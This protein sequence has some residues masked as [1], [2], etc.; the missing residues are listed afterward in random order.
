M[1]ISPRLRRLLIA[2]AGY[3]LALAAGIAVLGVGEV[4]NIL[5]SPQAVLRFSIAGGV[6]MLLAYVALP[7]LLSPGAR[8]TAVRGVVVSLALAGALASTLR[9]TT[10][11]D[12]APDLAAVAPVAAAA[13][14]PGPSVSRSAAGATPSGATPSVGT[15]SGGAPVKRTSRA[16]AGTPT[17]A[18][19]APPAP[20]APAAPVRL[21]TG[22]VAGINHKGAGSATLIRLADGSHVVRF[23]GLDVDNAPD[24]RVWLVRGGDREKTRDGVD[25]GK[26]KGNKGDQNYAAPAGTAVAPG[27]WTVLIWC[28][29]FAVPIANATLTVA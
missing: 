9:T 20:P 27:E 12:V 23:E 15:P 11:R 18:A 19:S 29:A 8:R 16:P 25:L 5:A 22:R 21:G 4:E 2:A 3:A 10:V 26:L 28:R 7:R 14:V 1:H 24:M 6:W 13:A 17:A